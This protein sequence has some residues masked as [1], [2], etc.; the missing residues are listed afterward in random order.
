MNT[1]FLLLCG[2]F[3]AL[4]LQACGDAQVSSV[5]GMSEENNTESAEA[6]EGPNG[7]RLLA[8]DGFNVELAIFESGVPPEYRAWITH[9]GE[10]VPPQD[11]ELRVTL[12]RLGDGV[13]DIRF[14]L[15]GEMLRGDTVIYE[16]HSF[17][18]YV[19][20]SYQ[21]NNY[22]WSYDSFE[23]RTRIEP[24]VRETLGITTEVAGPAVMEELLTVYGRIETNTDK[25]THI[26]ARFDG[27]IERV[28]AGIGER[29]SAGD[30]LLEIESNQGLNRYTVNS[31]VS[32]L[33]TARD[34]NV[35][36]QT[37][38]KALFTITDTSSVWADLSVFPTDVSRITVGMPVSINL[39]SVDEPVIGEVAM[40]LSE[41]QSNQ[42]FTV[43][44][45][46]DNSEG[47]IVPGSWLTAQLRLG[48]YEVPLAV[49]R[50]ALQTFRDF[51]VVYAQF[52]DEYEV[53]MLDLGRQSGDWAEVLGGLRPGTRYVS[54]NSFIL[55]AD[56]EK[57]G[58]SHDH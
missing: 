36:E 35:G 51:T 4:S 22:E 18:V 15:Q 42:A 23:G 34:A 37:D 16:P 12:T 9:N 21:G 6:P 13:D 48:E 20:A 24:S 58:A 45:V 11:V 26:S 46:L 40:I 41:V 31:P 56:V 49:R 44:V 27:V 55:K 25:V 33:V 2:A 10:P 19:S 53:R 29:V 14:E 17:S 38:G 7:G 47:R 8:D 32:G 30:A 54:E 50:D 39:A 5:S 52:G 57:S 1:K 28:N 3:V 43:R